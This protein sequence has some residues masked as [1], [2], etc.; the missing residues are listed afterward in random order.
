MNNAREGSTPYNQLMLTDIKKVSHRDDTE[1]G[2]VLSQCEQYRYLLWRIWD[3]KLP[4]WMFIMLNP[5]TA[6]HET[7]DA[8]ISRQIIRAK[9]A[10]AGGIVVANTGAIRETYSEK[11]KQHDD[12][13]GP[14]NIFWL[15]ETIPECDVHIAGWGAKARLFHGDKIVK[16]IFREMDIPLKALEINRDGSPKHPLYVGY[17]R[18]LVDYPLD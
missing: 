7:D 17:N 16:A 18:E 12:P 2:C 8:T 11:L 6:D 4:K 1:Y 14:H 10:G 15:K 5:S 3:D 9:M 13:I